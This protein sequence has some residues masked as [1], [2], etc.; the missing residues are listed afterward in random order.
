MNHDYSRYFNIKY[1]YSRV[2]KEF[3]T[4]YDYKEDI[5]SYE[6]RNPE[7]KY[8]ATKELLTI[9]MKKVINK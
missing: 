1:Y 8:D 9:L 2:E 4:N 7:W 6:E 5:N 3:H